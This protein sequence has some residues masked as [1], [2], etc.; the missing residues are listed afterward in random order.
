MTVLFKSKFATK[1]K[2]RWMKIFK[3]EESILR[4]RKNHYTKEEKNV[5]SE[6]SEGKVNPG[7]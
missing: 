2:G 1:N 6:E 3:N 7:K 4:G 5:S